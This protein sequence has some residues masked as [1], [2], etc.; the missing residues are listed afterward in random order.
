MKTLYFLRK[1]KKLFFKHFYKKK[2]GIRI[3]FLATLFGATACSQTTPGPG[4]DENHPEQL[5]LSSFMLRA[6]LNPDLKFDILADIREEDKEI[7]LPLPALLI[8]RELIADF[9]HNARAVYVQELLQ[10]SGESKVNF[11]TN[12]TF[13]LFGITTK[14]DYKVRVLEQSESDPPAFGGISRIEVQSPYRAKLFWTP[15]QD[16]ES[17]QDAIRYAIYLADSKEMLFHTA[18]IMISE[19][20]VTEVELSQLESNKIYFA[21]VRAVDSQGNVDSNENYLSFQSEKSATV[22]ISE[23]YFPDSNVDY[24]E[25]TI[26]DTGKLKDLEFYFRDKR[27]FKADWSMVFQKGDRIVVHTQEVSEDYLFEDGF[28]TIYHFFLPESGSITSTD[29]EINLKTPSGKFIDFICW[30]NGD[31]GKEQQ[32]SVD[33]AVA[34]GAWQIAG[35]ESTPQDCL[36]SSQVKSGQSFLR[37]QKEEGSSPDDHT[38]ISQDNNSRSD[39]YIYAASPGFINIF[40]YLKLLDAQ[41][42]SAKEI[43]LTFN[44]EITFQSISDPQNQILLSSGDQV[45]SISNYNPHSLLVTFNTDLSTEQIELNLVGTIH[46]AQGFPLSPEYQSAILAV[47]QDFSGIRINEW[48]DAGSNLDYV[49][50][51][52]FS[53]QE[54]FLEPDSI[55]LVYGKDHET[56]A[57][58][59]SLCIPLQDGE[60]GFP[61][62]NCQPFSE[63]V[64]IQ[65]G[66]IFLVVDRAVEALH[67]QSIRAFNGYNGK[68]FLSSESTLIG[69]MDRL[70]DSY[71][72]LCNKHCVR[73]WSQTPDANLFRDQVGTSTYSVLRADFIPGTHNTQDPANWAN[74]NA[75]EKRSCGFDNL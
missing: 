21:A 68:I 75:S 37:V 50:L 27:F 12:P 24:L 39:W 38:I 7:L 56:R 55:Q 70:S 11:S 33:D 9:E 72:S 67:L 18:P 20:G 60:P 65:P 31:W 15:A 61:G 30:S 49:E 3:L 59:L 58:L 73:T 34:K 54:L 32:A 29:F 69:S 51:K 42:M 43:I 64:R 5:R 36:D 40:P 4:A 57:S 8:S 2:A 14:S 47:D 62:D 44:K 74:G 6:A 48:A 19:A 28:Y 45:H 26:S 25:L 16:Q 52:N 13:S 46:D 22:L 1:S 53:D 23:V 71:A 10:T 17:S 41:R 35:I 66:E 63:G